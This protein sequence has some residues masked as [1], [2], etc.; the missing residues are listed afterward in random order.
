M[1]CKQAPP[2]DLKSFLCFTSV[3]L[4]FKKSTLL[5]L[6]RVRHRFPTH[7]R[8]TVKIEQSNVIVIVNKFIASFGRYAKPSQLYIVES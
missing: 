6:G 4:L 1:T 3:F 2:F 7:L 5:E 8:G